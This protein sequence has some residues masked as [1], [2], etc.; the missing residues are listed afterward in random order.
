MIQS[1][2]TELVRLTHSVHLG[3]ANGASA[4]AAGDGGIEHWIENSRP[5]NGET[6]HHHGQYHNCLAVAQFG[7]HLSHRSAGGSSTL[8]LRLS[9]VVI[10]SHVTTTFPLLNL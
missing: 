10:V 1:N 3:R 2:L 4:A 6:A 7:R 9:F 5:E 8:L